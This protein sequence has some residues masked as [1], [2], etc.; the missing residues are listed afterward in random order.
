MHQIKNNNT[1]FEVGRYRIS[2]MTQA[3]DD[4]GFD[5]MVSIRSGRGMASVDRVMHFTPSFDSRRAALRYA[6]A[7]GLAWAHG[8]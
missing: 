2:P 4:G 1:N 7:E 8:Q 3:R 6:R 5:A